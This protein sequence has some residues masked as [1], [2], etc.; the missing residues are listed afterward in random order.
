ML[1]KILAITFLSTLSVGAL[2]ACPKYQKVYGM[3]DLKSNTLKEIEVNKNAEELCGV[4]PVPMN[5]N[6]LV[7][8]TKN[9][10]SFQTKIYRS[11]HTY[12]DLTD[13]KKKAWKGGVQEAAEVEITSFIPDWYKDSTITITD[14]ST[15]KVLAETK[16][17]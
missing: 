10:V 17:K 9:K 8:I 12:F 3:L 16:L 13:Q 5:A 4:L 2:C 11:F 14:L 15:N 6:L 7:T 1:H